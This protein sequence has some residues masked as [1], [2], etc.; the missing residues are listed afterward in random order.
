MNTSDPDEARDQLDDLWN[1][2]DQLAA[3]RGIH[4]EP[5]WQYSLRELG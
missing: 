1:A 2:V 4:L 5:D 3:E